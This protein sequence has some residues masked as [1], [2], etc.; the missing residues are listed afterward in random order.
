MPCLSQNNSNTYDIHSW[1]RL[2][3]ANS[4]RRHCGRAVDHPYDEGG[5]AEG[6][7]AVGTA[8]SETQGWW[9]KIDT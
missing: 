9:G 3:T 2:S 6:E 5:G 1:P 8:R 4:A 7:S